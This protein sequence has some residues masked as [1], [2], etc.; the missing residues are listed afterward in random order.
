MMRHT[1]ETQK[2]SWHLWVVLA[3]LLSL[4]M[5]DHDRLPETGAYSEG[6]N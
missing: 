6:P 4:A 3:V 5:C 1:V 2:R